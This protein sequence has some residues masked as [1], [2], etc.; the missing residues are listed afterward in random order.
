M[1]DYLQKVLPRAHFTGKLTH[2]A[3]LTVLQQ[4]GFFVFPSTNDTFG[5]AVLEALSCGLPCV[6]FDKGGQVEMIK[7]G[8]NGFIAKNQVEFVQYIETL[9]KDDMLRTKMGVSAREFAQSY[10]WEANG[11]KL[12][13]ILSGLLDDES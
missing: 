5:I 9:H 13:T 2:A 6:V 7:H 3:L 11:K 8:V 4:A 12:L 1:F 10:N